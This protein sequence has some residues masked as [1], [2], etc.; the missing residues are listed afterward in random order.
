MR[1]S[2]RSKL[3]LLVLLKSLQKNPMLLMKALKTYST[4]QIAIHKSKKKC[5]RRSRKRQKE[6]ISSVKDVVCVSKK[7][8]KAVRAVEE[9]KPKEN[10][11]AAQVDPLSQPISIPQ[12]VLEMAKGAGIDL[13]RFVSTADHMR[14][15]ILGIEKGLTMIAEGMD[16]LEPLANLAQQYEMQRKQVMAQAGGPAGAT[17]PAQGMGMDRQFFKNMLMR[18]V[19]GG[20]ESENP[21]TK[22]FMEQVMRAGLE[23]MFMGN[24]LM[25]IFVQKT[26]P[27]MFAT[28]MRESEE[29]FKRV[30][31]GSK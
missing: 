21:M 17:M 26:A 9:K 1:R 2:K 24:A 7:I 23:S 16:K 20:G 10:E 13:E 11:E 29:T 15:R 12:N 25:K 5:Y 3:K 18:A 28:A 22:V 4:A 30:R 6:A 8:G 19:M 14:Q 31:G 27:E